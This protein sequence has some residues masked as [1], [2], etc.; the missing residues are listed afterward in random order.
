MPWR[1]HAYTVTIS[2]TPHCFADLRELIHI[3]T[4][5]I[6]EKKMS[7]LVI[8]SKKLVSL[9]ETVATVKGIT[10]DLGRSGKI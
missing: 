1:T 9:V 4:Y 2:D 10:V 5:I 8:F 6:E 3:T 7:S